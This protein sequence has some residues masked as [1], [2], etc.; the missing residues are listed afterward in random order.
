MSAESPQPQ[1]EAGQRTA[2]PPRRRSKRARYEVETTKYLAAAERFIRA[3][4]RRVADGD[5]I[6]LAGL[7]H[8]TDVLAEAIQHAV[9]GQRAMG[10][11][12]PAIAAATGKSPQAAQKRWGRDTTTDPA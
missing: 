4:G 1:V 5:E 9:D 7:L 3:A 12:W 11:T 6:E 10:K 8:M 2:Q